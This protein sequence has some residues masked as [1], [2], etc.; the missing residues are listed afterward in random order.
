[1]DTTSVSVDTLFS[2]EIQYIIPLFQRHYV[3]TEEDQWEPLWNDIKGRVHQR[4]TNEIHGQ[5]STH[6]TGAIVIQQKTT[7]A[8]YVN[9]YEIIDG[10]QRLT[11]FQIILCALRDICELCG[12]DVIKNQ[13]ERYLRN[14]VY[15]ASNEEP[16]KLIPTDFDRD[17]FISLIDEGINTNS[18]RSERSVHQA[19]TYFKH[20]INVYV[21]GDEQK[22]L[23]L[24][25]SIQHDFGFVQ[26]RL[27]IYDEPE[28]IFESL[29]ARGK[30]LLQFDLLRNHLFLK[31]RI[32]KDRD[33]LYTDYWK[34]FEN[35]DWEQEVKV[36]RSKIMLSERFFEH[37]IMAKT[38]MDN[39][40]PLFNVYQKNIAINNDVDYELSE[41]KR[42]S[43]VYR[44]LTDS[45]PNSEIGSAMGFFKVFEIATLYPF[46]LFLKN[47]LEVSDPDFLS[48]LHILESYTMRR[49]ACL[50]AIATKSY[51]QFFSRLI[52]QMR[53]G[54]FDLGKF[55][56]ILSEE[57]AEASRWPADSEVRTF[58]GLGTTGYGM[59]DNTI[60]YILYRIELQKQNENPF[61]EADELVFKNRLSIEHVMP[62]A[63]QDEWSL[64]LD[65]ET[66]RII[67]YKDLF[68]NEYKG[69]YSEW[70]KNPSKD[71]L[72]DESYDEAFRC[73]R[74]RIEALHSIGNL[75]LVTSKLNSALSNRPFRDKRA[76][77]SENSMLIMNKEICAH[78]NWDWDQIFERTEELFTYF[79]SIW[80]SADDFARDA[81]YSSN[82]PVDISQHN[83]QESDL[84]KEDSVQEGSGQF[85][86][87]QDESSPAD[88]QSSENP[89]E[90]VQS[91]Q[92]N[93][94]MRS[95]TPKSRKVPNVGWKKSKKSTIYTVNGQQYTIQCSIG[96]ILY[97]KKQGLTWKE[98]A[99]SFGIEPYHLTDP[100][101]LRAS[102]EWERAVA[103]N[104]KLGN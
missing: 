35:P 63:W 83:K 21:D 8:G 41:L 79:C 5:H 32:E 53:G 90:T 19:Y 96:Q 10:Q 43:V 9:Q 84:G 97:R 102:S 72:A 25:R 101:Y 17:S 93:R 58:L 59:K 46:L 52:D 91:Q 37:F 62:K 50:S 64:P 67:Y 6:F 45:D 78:D 77:L 1:M 60:R 30:P 42:Y 7:N 70:E 88:V 18:E 89:H 3:W 98:V 55:I 36:G 61:L 82:P 65:E 69:N 86:P 87:Q 2:R 11:T 15:N 39:V 104:K 71:G 51:T 73:A 44:K 95:K 13:T 20:Q 68:T 24:F 85:Y 80:P 29:N 57:D 47:E 75:T 33:R 38:G 49:M 48:V 76:S 27:D 12:F 66:D 34:H 22:T 54:R 81:P 23:G 28:R 94:G 40:R 16:Y 4:L 74:Q 92:R 26:I 31:A 99:K 56:D 100:A 103:K 14:E